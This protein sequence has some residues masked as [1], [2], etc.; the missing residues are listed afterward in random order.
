MRI[1]R[2]A[3]QKL[4]LLSPKQFL[5]W[6]LVGSF[7]LRLGV[8][9]YFGDIDSPE[10]YEHGEIANNLYQGYGFSMHWPY[11]P[12]DSNRIALF[13]LPPEHEGAFLPPLHPY[14]IYVMYVVFGKG[15][16]A[17][18]ALLLLNLLTSTFIPFVTY[19]LSKAL[20]DDPAARIVS[21]LAMIF[22]PATMAIT[23]FSGS[24]YYQL[25]ALINLLMCVK[26][27]QKGEV[28][29]YAYAAISTGV[30]ILL[31]SEYLI[32]G[33]LLFIITYIF[34]S[35]RRKMLGAL[36]FICLVTLIVG[37]WTYRNYKLFD[38]FVPVLSHP[39]YEIWRGN[40]PVAT[41]TTTD[42]EGNGIWV[43]SKEF[44]HIIQDLD[45][46]TYDNK[47]EVL[48]DNIFKN[49]VLSYWDADPMRYVLLAW[50][51]LFY[52]ITI[53]FNNPLSRN[54]YYLFFSV[55]GWCTII[56]G[57]FGLYR[58][59]LIDNNWFYLLLF[60]IFLL[61]YA[62]LTMSTVMLPRYQIYILV[63]LMPVSGVALSNIRITQ[64]K[65]SG[66]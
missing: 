22:L 43:N 29:Y 40:N 55:A 32:L 30:M 16:T 38:T 47:F 52:F 14:L 15:S 45:A 4:E 6:L 17:I 31:R 37:P 10:M 21:V 33:F 11:D 57:F 12:I 7:V 54:H 28:K 35:I 44:P 39:W 13:R 36:L 26:L 5:L 56:Y 2:A 42:T 53:D 58:N 24:V 18:A 1:L 34:L 65:E 27:Y 48:A 59:K 23:T 8:T 19:H 3:Q 61:Y 62:A 60:G 63:A 46:L 41:G 25:F 66:E 51:K 50:K 20:S 9:L 64:T 49:E